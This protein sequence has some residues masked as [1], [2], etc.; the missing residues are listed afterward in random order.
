MANDSWP[1]T[2]QEAVVYFS[3]LERAQEFL[4]ALRWPHGITCPICGSKEVS[5]LSTRRLWKCKADHACRQFSIK[6]GSIFADSPLG[7]DK[8]LV[9]IWI[10]VT[11]KNGV[12]SYEISRALHVSQQS[13][14]FMLHR[15]RLAMQDQDG[16]QLDGEVEV[17]ETFIGGKARNMHAHKR[18][19]KITGTGGSGKVAVAGLLARHG[20]GGKKHSTVRTQV[21]NTRKRVELDPLVHK[22]VKPGSAIMTDELKSYDAL[23]PDYVHNVINHAEKYVEGNVHTNG[24]ENFWSLLKRCIRGT[25]VSVEPF[26]LFRYLDEEAFRFNEREHEDGDRGRFVKVCR[27]IFGKRLMYKE[28]TGKV[29]MA[30]T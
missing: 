2:L 20:H 13:T 22:H 3:D 8:W 23:A 16:G 17:D 25:Y 10:I 30:T 7:L 6:N 15:I 29:A 26:H 4:V 1:R 24:M 18:A 12:S 27:A 5:Y 9:A 19:E 14:W 21:V 28:L 11:C